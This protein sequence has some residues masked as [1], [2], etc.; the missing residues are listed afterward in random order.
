MLRTSRRFLAFAAS[1]L[2]LWMAVLAQAADLTNV[3]ADEALQRLKDGNQRFVEGKAAHPHQQADRRAEIAKSQHPF[4]IVVCCSDSRVPPEIVF[5]QGLGDVFVIRTAGNV[6]D[7]VGLGSV[8]YAV[9]HFGVPL[10]V[11]LGHDRCGAVRAAVAGG[12]APGHV[13]AIV[14]A[15]RPAVEKTK[16]EPGDPVANAVRAN[17]NDMVQ[18][19]CTTAPILPDRVQAGTLTVVGA[20]YD[21]DDGHVEFFK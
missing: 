17:V 5:D 9:E 16:A 4:A 19:L 1:A 18:K 12:E 21:M 14:S 6:V 11:V 2:C 10:V 20:R 7:D 3:T 8:E 15:I 13:E